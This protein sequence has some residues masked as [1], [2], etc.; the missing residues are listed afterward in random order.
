MDVVTV[1]IVGLCMALAAAGLI[2]AVCGVIYLAIKGV[3]FP[4]VWMALLV[5]GFTYL[6]SALD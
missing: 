2:V 4:I 5:F 6:L 1:A 3:F